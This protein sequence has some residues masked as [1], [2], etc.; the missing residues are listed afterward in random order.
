[1]AEG[2]PERF[3]VRLRTADG[4]TAG[5]G[6]LVGDRQV[7][8]CAHVVN[9]A[10]GLD[11]RAQSQPSGKVLLDFPLLPTDPGQNRTDLCR[12][13]RVV[14]WLP[15][16]R[17]GAAGDD[18]AGLELDAAAP[19]SARAARLILN[20]PRAGRGT[21][22]FGYPGSPPRPD[23]AW[24]PATVR[25]Q[26][27]GGRIQ[28]DS[29]IEAALRVQPG[30]SGSPV[31]D[32]EAGRVVGLIAAASLRTNERDSYAIDA[33]RLRLAWPEVLLRRPPDRRITAGRQTGGHDLPPATELTVLHVSDPQF[34]RHHLFGGNGF[35]D[36]DKDLDSLFS[37]LHDDLDRLATDPGLG[38]DLIVVTGDLAEW[39][40]RSEFDKVNRFLAALAEAT[41]LPRRHV[42]VVPGNHDVNRMAA[43]AYFAEQES[44]EREPVPPYW[45]KWRQFV[46]AFEQ[47]YDG[48][49]GVTFTPDEPWTLFEIP[50]LKVVVAGL[51]STMAESHRDLDHY[52]L[53]GEA[54]LRWFAQRL[55]GYRDRGWLRLAA[56]HHNVV[57][58]AT[59][60]EENLRDVD[61]LDR[62]LGRP[63]LVNL[64]LHGHTHDGRLQRLPSGLVA[65]STGSAAVDA[66]ARP[67]EVP[68][69]Y[70]LITIR[71]DGFTRY[72]RQYALG[73][74]RW[75]GDPRISASG[76][77]WRDH[78]T[79]LMDSV[80]A[81]LPELALGPESGTR[82]PGFE[83]GD[84]LESAA[85]ARESSPAEEFLERVVDATRAR[86]PEAVLTPRPRSGYL[87]VTRPLSGGG[88][89]Q[90]AVGVIDGPVD[91]GPAGEAAIDRFVDD[92]HSRFAAADPNVRSQL[93]H[94]G[95]RAS[96]SL[97]ARA[98]RRG[99]QL[100]NFV[101]YQ[102]L[103]DLGPLVARQTARLTGD[104]VYPP[105]LYVPQRYRLL[106]SPSNP[107]DESV[108]SGLLEQI[109]RWL[110]ADDARLVMV[111]GDFGRGKTS[112]LRQ[113]ARILP[114]ELPGVLPMLVELRSLEKAPTLDGLLAQ[115]LANQGVEDIHV[116]KLRYMIQSGRL[117]LL[118]D[119]FDELELRVGYDNAA[120]YLRT[121]LESVRDRAKVVLTSRTQHFRSTEQ[122]NVAL[123][124]AELGRTELGERV[125]TVAGSRVVVLEDF[126]PEQIRQ[127]LTN[128]YDGDAG[129]ATS[130]F[131]LLN[132]VKDLIGLARNPRMLSFMA[133]L[134]E[135]RLRAVQREH[136]IISAAELYREI[137]DFWLIGE[138]NR[139][140][141]RRGRPSL[142]EQDRL[143]AC[144]ALALRLWTSS[145]PA[146]AA[147]DLTAAVA[148]RLTRLAERGYSADQAGHAI[149][150]GSL[151]VHNNDGGFAFV[152]QSIMEWL[153]A[154]EAAK[155]LGDSNRPSIKSVRRMS[156]LMI[157][158][159]ADL[160]GHARAWAWARG[161]LADPDSGEI[162]KINALTLT[163]RLSV[164]PDP[165]VRRPPAQALSGIDLRGAD[166]N[167]RDL[168]GAD[169]R[170]ANLRGMHLTGIDFTGA[171][172]RQADFTGARLTGGSLA[173][174]LLADSRWDRA[175]LLGVHGV[176]D[177][178]TWPELRAA[179]IAGHDRAEPMIQPSSPA[180]NVA[181]SPAGDLLAITRLNAVELV[182][183]TDDRTLRLLT[184]HTDLIRTLA[185]SPDGTAIVT[186]SADRTARVWDAA[187]GSV[188]SVLH[189]H[190]DT[191]IAAAFVADGSRIVT[192]SAD[193]STRFWHARSGTALASTP[194][195][196][197]IDAHRYPKTA[198]AVAFSADAT[199]LAIS[200]RGQA[201]IWDTSTGTT[202]TTLTA[203]T[204][205]I[206][207][208]AFNPEGTQLAAA[209]SFRPT[210]IWDLSTGVSRTIASPAALRAA[211][212]AHIVVTDIAAQIPRAVTVS[213][214]ADGSR[215]VIVSMDNGARIW[216]LTTGESHPVPD[217]DGAAG[218]QRE[219]AVSPNGAYLVSISQDQ[220][221]RIRDTTT[222]ATVSTL[223]GLGDPILSLA[224][225]LDGT[226]LA[227]ATQDYTIRIWDTGT[228][229]STVAVPSGSIPKRAL[230][231][232]LA[233][234]RDGTK[235]VTIIDG[236][237]RIWDV[238]TATSRVALAGSPT[239]VTFSP[240][241]T[242]LVAASSDRTVQIW[243]ADAHLTQQLLPRHTG[244]ILAVTFSPDG[245]RF[246]TASD[247]MS[248]IYETS[249]THASTTGSARA[250]FAGH[251]ASVRAQAFSPDGS[252]L[253]TAS[254]DG[255][256][257]VW[258][259]DTGAQLIV[260]AQLPNRTSAALFADGSYTL[261]G[262][263]GDE[264]WWSLKLCRFA[265]G[266]LDPYV[267][268]LRRRN[269]S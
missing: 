240:D 238:S 118:F 2:P 234:S 218:R 216:N 209:P 248:Q 75:I 195:S 184:G 161:V 15:P 157:D 50:D 58:G 133:A 232:A 138:A 42:V 154:Q 168:R 98:R 200:F 178:L 134:D 92:V 40:L 142:D 235:L 207:A 229:L 68:N 233:L 145:T 27:G 101:E 193:G 25:G 17:E 166:L 131:A 227:T 85:P 62:H 74:R 32:D 3:V 146:I 21:R 149:G 182:S 237:A 61:D 107:G 103:L 260:L 255:A 38:P 93:V 102:G 71:R 241:G 217:L 211:R 236:N 225:S 119:G 41:E 67:A 196:P 163:E 252:R 7:V 96:E 10:L 12:T 153:V 147:D 57:R 97:V 44:D 210:Q 66:G 28:L 95:P 124:R 197:S 110:E 226:R 144:T 242:K 206:R 204:G 80:E 130:R 170:G 121:L 254:N 11:R 140:R 1:M 244:G 267:P 84:D 162:A 202:R 250:L 14:Q 201:L 259:I 108:R 65:L 245:R 185:F 82:E 73:Q 180:T 36:A 158:F 246:A 251:T 187:T 136:G 266:E 249:Q 176:D 243:D 268:D 173:Q 257:R 169:L 141:H 223:T 203:H 198:R 114:G 174:T 18:V 113:L 109:Q 148:S 199:S 16:P 188:R 31:W 126:S 189:G 81:A 265:P 190:T 256:V 221:I 220:T 258:D 135:E 120:D 159:F 143:E 164:P 86:E 22:V 39:G 56:V 264:L 177:L 116:G 87:R 78:H 64:L 19:D 47:F 69:Q 94:G 55:S 49:D 88:A 48:V 30:F 52:G 23:G 192:A 104:P 194:K 152:H 215:L 72:A 181:F 139:Q 53:V 253:A 261:D 5:M 111:L 137:V 213:F 212:T 269:L 63:G 54:Q 222:G 128:H 9:T 46:A 60:D 45:P 167:G 91:S 8:T 230:A 35:T 224:F 77:D 106:T 90:W 179:A 51:N 123:G 43:Q 24:V 263:P 33:D 231:P 160:A 83:A 37:R 4:G 127:F 214:T 34:G 26:V 156:R 115:H 247:S 129:R 117:A 150:S 191:V 70:Q 262:D 239:M 125:D 76:S 132:D 183:L 29:G 105:G 208:L 99:V 112:L 205:A 175:A 13:A 171:D 155:T 219:L 89:A 59:L 20:L 228:G 6:V 151:L 165:G 100:L 79:E 186:A 122:V 172:L